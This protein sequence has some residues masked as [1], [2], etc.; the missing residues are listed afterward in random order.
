[1]LFK[2]T[3]KRSSHQRETQALQFCRIAHKSVLAKRLKWTSIRRQC[4][5]IV[6]ASMIIKRKTKTMMLTS[7]SEL[8]AIIPIKTGIL[9][10]MH[11]RSTR[12]RTHHQRPQKVQTLVPHPWE[13]IHLAHP[14]STANPLKVPPL[15]IKFAL[16]I[17]IPQLRPSIYRENATLRRNSPALTIKW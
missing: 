2:V 17:R 12:S 3:L 10:S 16:K 11:S 1:M 9:I 4:L 7:R 6:Q 13:C 8:L 5:T 14:L 15:T